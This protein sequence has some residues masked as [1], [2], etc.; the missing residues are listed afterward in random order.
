M[1]KIAVA[2][3][4]TVV[5]SLINSTFALGQDLGQS[6]ASSTQHPWAKVVVN[7]PLPK[8]GAY[9]KGVSRTALSKVERPLEKEPR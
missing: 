7:H 8:H 5:T 2:A 6:T 3:A 4:I 1:K 9:Y